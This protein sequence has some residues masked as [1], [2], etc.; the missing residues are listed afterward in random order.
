MKPIPSSRPTERVY[1]KDARHITNDQRLTT[2]VKLNSLDPIRTY[3]VLDREG[4]VI[5]QVLQPA[6]AGLRGQGTMLLRR[7]VPVVRSQRPLGAA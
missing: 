5:G 6:E 1:S 2:M 3:D 4:R 7:P